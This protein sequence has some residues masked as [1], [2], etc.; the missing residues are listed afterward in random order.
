M[1]TKEW[2]DEEIKNFE[3]LFKEFNQQWSEI[4]KHMKTRTE[5]EVRSFGQK[6]NEKKKEASYKSNTA[7]KQCKKSKIENSHEGNIIENNS[8]NNVSENHSE[9]NSIGINNIVQSNPKRNYMENNPYVNVLKNFQKK[10]GY[11]IERGIIDNVRSNNE[12]NLTN[13]QNEINDIVNNHGNNANSI[14]EN[15][16]NPNIIENDYTEESLDIMDDVESYSASK[17][18][19]YAI[20]NPIKSN[21]RI[22]RRNHVKNNT[23]HPIPIN[24]IYHNYEIFDIESSSEYDYMENFNDMSDIEAYSECNSTHYHNIRNLPGY[25]DE[26]SYMENYNEGS[27]IQICNDTISDTSFENNK[28]IDNENNYPNETEKYNE[29]I[30]LKENYNV[31]APIE[32]HNENN[33]DENHKENNYN[34]NENGINHVENHNENVYQ[35]N[36]HNINNYNA[37]D[38]NAN[39]YNINDHNGNKNEA[40]HNRNN[41]LGSFNEIIVIENPSIISYTESQNEH[42]HIGSHSVNSYTESQNEHNS[43]ENNANVPIKNERNLVESYNQNY[44][45]INSMEN[46]EEIKMVENYARNEGIENY[47]IESLLVTFD[48]FKERFH[49]YEQM[50]RSTSGPPFVGIDPY[51]EDRDTDIILQRTLFRYSQME[52][53]LNELSRESLLAMSFLLNTFSI[54]TIDREKAQILKDKIEAVYMKGNKLIP[55]L[56]GTCLMRCKEIVKEKILQLKVMNLFLA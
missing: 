54:S 53:K 43:D 18:H 21:N 15:I 35:E 55:E 52:H 6:Y 1:D 12:I 31:D 26:S 36:D 19:Y 17:E 27:V 56:A 39:N 22:N 38:H 30:L 29:I 32:H 41:H 8:E 7:Y 47:Q 11:H 51:I 49:Q 13:N 37:N 50:G 23:Q 40:H 33:Y 4:S 9:N 16:R 24:P 25:Y 28:A 45:Q 14:N 44:N 3:R 5:E 2:N 48:L 42:S 34:E 46:N 10:M 20:T